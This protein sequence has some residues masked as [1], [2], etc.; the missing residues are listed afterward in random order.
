M[1]DTSSRGGRSACKSSCPRVNSK[2]YVG[3]SARNARTAGNEAG[4]RASTGV[5]SVHYCMASIYRSPSAQLGPI[6]CRK[7]SL[8]SS[9]AVVCAV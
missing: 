8:T 6:R 3:L 4:R 1:G 7:G 2:P 9:V 5:V